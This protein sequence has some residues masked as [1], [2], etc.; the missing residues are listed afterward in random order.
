MSE[1]QKPQVEPEDRG[2]IRVVHIRESK[3]GWT[4]DPRQLKTAL[5]DAAAK[6]T[7]IA[8]DFHDVRYLC[9]STIGT[10]IT[11]NRDL[12]HARAKVVFY[13]MQPYVRETFLALGLNKVLT[14]C[15]TEE[16]ALFCL[17]APRD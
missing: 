5:T 4:V 16:E 17:G 2:G 9:S 8:V 7:R 12:R 14:I 6:A 11:F 1:Q 10:I 3:L 13:H 15:D